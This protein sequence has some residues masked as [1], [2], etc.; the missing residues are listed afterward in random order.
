MKE[1]FSYAMGNDFFKPCA[2]FL[3]GEEGAQI[4]W[5]GDVKD[6]PELDRCFTLNIKVKN[7]AGE[8]EMGHEYIC[9]YTSPDGHE[10]L[11]TKWATLGA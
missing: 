4:P 2:T 3:K 11:E 6:A 1:F 5:A 7:D 10:E 8:I 9:I